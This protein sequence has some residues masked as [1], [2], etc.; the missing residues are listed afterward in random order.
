MGLQIEEYSLDIP[1]GNGQ[2]FIAIYLY[3]MIAFKK[4]DC[5]YRK[6]LENHWRRIFLIKLE[7]LETD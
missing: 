5:F 7:W 4:T 2:W 3:K 6:F 1:Q